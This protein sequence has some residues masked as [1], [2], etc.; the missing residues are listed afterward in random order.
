MK[1][2]KESSFLLNEVESLKHAQIANFTTFLTR[3]TANNVASTPTHADRASLTRRHTL[4][5]NGLLDTVNLVWGQ[6]ATG[7]WLKLQRECLRSGNVS[8]LDVE[9]LVAEL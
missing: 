8:L 7:L 2:K 1:K 3:L 4:Q 6:I 9:R 5:A